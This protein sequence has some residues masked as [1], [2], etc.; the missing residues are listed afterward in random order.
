M[1]SVFRE[2]LSLNQLPNPVPYTSRIRVRPAS[3][4]GLSPPYLIVPPVEPSVLTLRCWLGG[5]RGLRPI[6]IFS[7]A[8]A[9]PRPPLIS[10]AGLGRR[11]AW[12][13][14][15][16]TPDPLTGLLPSRRVEFFLAPCPLR[17]L[18][19][20]LRSLSPP[21]L[22]LRLLFERPSSTSS[23][24]SIPRGASPTRAPSLSLPPL[25]YCLSSLPLSRTASLLRLLLPPLRRWCPPPFPL[26][27][28]LLL[29]H[30][31]HAINAITNRTTKITAAMTPPL[32][33]SVQVA[34]FE[35]AG[36]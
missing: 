6:G 31:A 5:N 28:C 23:A 1:A 7:S 29:L 21:A 30:N 18:F 22:L 35:G 34:Q 9:S 24:I 4:S 19:E 20:E 36:L 26:L 14:P 17:L 27:F 15:P 11:P 25:L 32:S 33:A 10:Y 12:P 3:L 16:T 2:N 13:S 8:G